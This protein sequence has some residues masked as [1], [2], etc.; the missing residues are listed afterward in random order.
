M[1]QIVFRT[2]MPLFPAGIFPFNKSI[3]DETCLRIIM[4]TLSYGCCE[5]RV[6]PQLLRSK[7][8]R[9]FDRLR[10]AGYG[11]F[12]MKAATLKYSAYRAGTGL[13]WLPPGSPGGRTRS[14]STHQ[15]I[16]DRGF[17]CLRRFLSKWHLQD[18]WNR[19]D[20]NPSMR[21]HQKWAASPSLLKK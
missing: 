17:L 14:A 20:R 9:R 16:S 12:V 7:R 5:F 6:A 15:G 18:R 1:E 13:K 10:V 21:Y 8:D 19:I 4:I 11:F 2:S 3:V